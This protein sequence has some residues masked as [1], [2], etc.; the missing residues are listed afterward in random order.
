MDKKYSSTLLALLFLLAFRT[1][2]DAQSPGTLDPTFGTNGIATTSFLTYASECKAMVAQN[3]GKIILGGQYLAAGQGNMAFARYNTN[4]TLDNGF[5]TAGKA[6][7]AFTNSNVTLA[8]V[9]LLSNGKILAAGNS[10]NKPTI[11]RLNANGTVD[12]SFGTS[13]VVNFDGGLVALS[14]MMVLPDG[15][16]VGCGIAD[17]GAGKLFA[18]FR[19]NADGSADNT[20]GTANGFAYANIGNQP[21]LTRMAVQTDGKILLTGTVYTN[22]STVYDLVLY[23]F[24]ASGMPDTGFGTNGKVSSVL[25]TNSAYELGNAI[26]V[27]SDGKIVVAGRI[28]NSGPTVFV[29]VRYNSNGS[30]DTGFGTN[31][32][33]KINYFNSLDEAKAV[34]IQSDGKIL[35]AGTALNGSVREL[36]LARLTGSGTLDNSFGTGGKTT[37]PIGTKVFGEAMTI[38]PN[39]KIAVAGSATV[40]NLSQ[41]AVARYFSGLAVGTAEQDAGFDGLQVYPNPVQAGETVTLRFKLDENK[42]C[43]FHLLGPDGRL[44]RAYTP[45][46]LAAGEYQLFFDLPNGLPAGRYVLQAGTESGVAGLPLQVLR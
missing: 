40:S 45:Q 2:L 14:D 9:R 38:L 10:D 19:R 13:G 11:V 1:G 31:G 25:S 36:A 29:I 6:N 30:I 18:A 33:I 5:G 27:Q 8:A 28:A 24:T 23:R 21:T 41:F 34:A 46:T 3:D 12:N 42:P 20:F 43:I 32:S 26:A 17:L 35:V 15:K 7:I 44:I 22:A 37:T 16:I 4:G 39:G